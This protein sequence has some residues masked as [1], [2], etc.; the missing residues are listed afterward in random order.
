SALIE[1]A[2]GRCEY[3]HKPDDRALNPYSHE[4]DHILAEKHGG[5]T[6]LDN[7]AY[8]CFQC[9]RY[10]G[11]DLTSLDPHT[12]EVTRLFHPRTQHWDHHF[13]LST[14]GTMTS[15]TSE[16]RTTVRLLRL[17]APERIQTRADLISAGLLTPT[18]Q[19]V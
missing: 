6:V 9:N 11:S 1:R 14:D 17:N 12:N 2:G 13:I 10:K 19:G 8:A 4:V 15:C 18:V 7:L 16:G 5:G 3:C